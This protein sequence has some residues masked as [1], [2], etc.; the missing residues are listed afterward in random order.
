[1]ACFY[2]L[3]AYRSSSPNE[4]GKFPVVFN[5]KAG[6][7]DQPIFLPCGQC[8]GCRL[9]RSRQ[10]A[11]RCIHE[12]KMYERNCFL[13][14][15]YSEENLPENMSLRYSDFQAFMKRFKSAVRYNEGKKIA[16]GIKFYM[17]GEYGARFGRPHYHAIIF[18]YDFADKT[19]DSFGSNG[20]KLFVSEFL[21]KLWPHGVKEQQKIGSVTYE[22]AAYV[23]RYIMKKITGDDAVAY[24]GDRQPEFNKMSN[25]IGKAWFQKYGADAL[26]NDFI[27]HDGKKHR[28]PRF[29][30]NMF[31]VI[32]YDLPSLLNKNPVLRGKAIVLG[33]KGKRVRAAKRHAADNT[34]ERRRVR[35][36]VQLARLH[37]LKREYQ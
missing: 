4:N 1:M 33:K 17:C 9:E 34:P 2:P 18:N 36:K 20:D 30:D 37:K 10:W 27:I 11:L 6:L 14:L 7:Y 28:V 32:P 25:G 24:Y 16:D 22:S 31:E 23:A 19:F 26:R 5:Y 3:H 21:H 29:Y 8:I 15:T 12:A 35:E 13:T